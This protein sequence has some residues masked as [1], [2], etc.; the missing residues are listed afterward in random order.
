MSYYTRMD[1]LNGAVSS[2][3]DV[4]DIEPSEMKGMSNTEKISLVTETIADLNANMDHKPPEVLSGERYRLN[5]YDEHTR[6]FMVSKG[7]AT[8]LLPIGT[9]KRVSEIIKSKLIQ[10]HPPKSIIDSQGQIWE[11]IQ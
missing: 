11:L 5:M 1:R 6:N 2:F 4:F 8:D 10:E 3:Q 7:L 9:E